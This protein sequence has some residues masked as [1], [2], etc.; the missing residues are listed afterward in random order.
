MQGSGEHSLC[1]LEVPKTEE[2][3]AKQKWLIYLLKSWQMNQQMLVI[4]DTGSV[5]GHEPSLG[6][7]SQTSQV[8]KFF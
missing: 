2:T 6:K 3:R 4:T 1:S 8:H 7:E 5:E